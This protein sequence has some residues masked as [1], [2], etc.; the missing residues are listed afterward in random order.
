MGSTDAQDGRP[1]RGLFGVVDRLIPPILLATSET[2]ARARVLVISSVGIG[3]LTS[4]SHTI[5]GLTV[6]RDTGFW[7]GATLIAFFFA[8]PVVQRVSASP[9]LAGGLLAVSLALGLPV[10][11]SQVGHF[12]AP[13]IAFFACVP[14][15][16]TFF[17]GSRAGLAGALAMSAAVIALGT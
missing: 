12:P 16:A 4:I 17:L 6:S 10:V 14:L 5:R 2:R 3:L 13:V 1:G 15:L 9:R 7:L 8:L 11:H